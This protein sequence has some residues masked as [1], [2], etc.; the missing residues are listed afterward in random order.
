MQFD[1]QS[2]NFCEASMI[3]FAAQ[4]IYIKIINDT[5]LQPSNFLFDFY[6]VFQQND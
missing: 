6:I 5:P 2:N 1:L 3:F 4:A